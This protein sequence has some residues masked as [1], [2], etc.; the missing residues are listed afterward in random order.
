MG[1]FVLVELGGFTYGRYVD[2]SMGALEGT[3]GWFS[4]GAGCRLVSANRA[5]NNQFVYNR[6]LI[7]VYTH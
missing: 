5:Y 1:V 2:Y 6:K 7:L 3:A 4:N